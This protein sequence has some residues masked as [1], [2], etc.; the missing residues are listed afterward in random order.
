MQ[1]KVPT[2]NWELILFFTINISTFTK[3]DIKHLF[4]IYYELSL[5]FYLL[6]VFFI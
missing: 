4:K 3:I 2:Y 1:P 5:T 6:F